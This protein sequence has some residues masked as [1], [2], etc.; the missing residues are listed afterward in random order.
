MSQRFVSLNGL[1][2]ALI[3]ADYPD[4]SLKWCY[5]HLKEQD[6]ENSSSLAQLCSDL[7]CYSLSWQ[8]GQVHTHRAVINNLNLAAKEIVRRRESAEW[9]HEWL[10]QS[11]G[12]MGRIRCVSAPP[13]QPPTSHYW[14]SART[15]EWAT[16]TVPA[17]KD[18]TNHQYPG[19]A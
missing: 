10:H 5:L 14:A 16:Q 17:R 19:S 15:W 13:F 8:T 6:W 3:P 12:C 4:A 11:H 7:L 2:P 18:S 1:R 9:F